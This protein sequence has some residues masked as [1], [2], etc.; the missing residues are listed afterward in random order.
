MD[1][2]I[3]GKRRLADHLIPCLPAHDGYVEVLFYPAAIREIKM[4]DVVKSTL[5]TLRGVLI[6][7]VIGSQEYSSG[8]HRERMS[9]RIESRNLRR[10]R[11]SR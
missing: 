9:R 6:T 7:M 2:R 3:G 10:R 5:D 4:P 1:I 8:R 11:I